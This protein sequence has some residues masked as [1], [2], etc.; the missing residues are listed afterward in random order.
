MGSI[1]EEIRFRQ[2]LCEYVLKH[3]VAKAARRYQTNRQFAYRQLEKYDGTVRSLALWSRRP[4][5]SP[6][7]HSDGEL[8]LIWRIL[9]RNGVYGF[10]EVYVR[11]WSK[12]YGVLATCA[13]RFER[14]AAGN[15]RFIGRVTRSTIAWTE[16]IPE[17]K[18]RCRFPCY[19]EQYYQIT[20][21]D[22]YSRK[23]VLKIVKEKSTYETG[24]FLQSLEGEKGFTICIIQVGNSTEFVN[25]GRTE[26][27]KSAVWP[28]PWG[29]LTERTKRSFME[30]ECS[31]AKRP[32]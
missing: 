24:N 25:D 6:N 7:A 21:A 3:A 32:E 12:G 18:F 9:K 11:Y 1:T 13:A 29:E 5:H 16:D 4:R 30:E 23:L 15:R 22:E 27:R 28:F 10:A 8:D 14:K 31:L 19:R 20:A 2:R 17:R 26:R